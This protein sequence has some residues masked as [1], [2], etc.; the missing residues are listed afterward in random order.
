MTS[1]GSCHIYKLSLSQ[2]SCCFLEFPLIVVDK[3]YSHLFHI[4]TLWSLYKLLKEHRC[5]IIEKDG[6]IDQKNKI[7][8]DHINYT[9]KFLLCTLHD[10]IMVGYSLKEDSQLYREELDTGNVQV[11]SH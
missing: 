6:K 8:N 2:H 10:Q 1:L 9:V 4:Q 5:T 11:N 3:R 7:S